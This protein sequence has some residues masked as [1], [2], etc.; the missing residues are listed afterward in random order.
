MTGRRFY[1]ARLILQEGELAKYSDVNLMPG[2]PVETLM[3]TD[4]RTIMSYLVKP[5][6]DQVTRA[7]REE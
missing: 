2:M 6:L 4:D 5:F 3:K 7:F 1:I